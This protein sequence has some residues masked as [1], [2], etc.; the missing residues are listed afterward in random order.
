MLR[1]TSQFKD[2]THGI[3]TASL[4]GRSVLQAVVSGYPPIERLTTTHRSAC[5]CAKAPTEQEDI[6]LGGPPSLIVELCRDGRRVTGPCI[7]RPHIAAP[8]SCRHRDLVPR[9]VWRHRHSLGSARREERYAEHEPHAETVCARRE[10]EAMTPAPS[11]RG[12]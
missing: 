6:G 11:L 9:E 8:R 12:D 7:S 10:P 2:V 3:S 1:R 4:L 5:Y